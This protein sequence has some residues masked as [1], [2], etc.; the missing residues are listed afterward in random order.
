[1]P[2]PTLWSS[3]P[4]S[5]LQKTASGAS[6]PSLEHSASRLESLMLSISLSEFSEDVDINPTSPRNLREATI[7]YNA[8]LRS[9]RSFTSGHNSMRRTG[10]ISTMNSEDSTLWAEPLTLDQVLQSNP[11]MSGCLSKFNND[12]GPGSSWT[13]HLFVLSSTD[14]KLYE[15]A[16]NHDLSVVPSATLPVAYFSPF[17]DSGEQAWILRVEGRS[18]NPD[19][20][21]KPTWTLKC[22]NEACMIEWSQYLEQAVTKNTRALNRNSVECSRDSG[23]FHRLSFQAQPAFQLVQ[24]RA[25]SRQRSSSNALSPKIPNPERQSQMKLMHEQYMRNQQENAERRR[26]EYLAR[27]GGATMG[28]NSQV[29]VVGQAGGMGDEGDE[30]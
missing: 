21:K 29:V 8:S 30:K 18:L 5:R 26:R 14:G 13:Q 27:S 2:E 15:F 1:M 3:S 11:D 28:R 24:S 20:L 17:F 12:V 6:M 7:A 23:D 25:M 16:S 22:D 10:S 9:G 4:S 19:T